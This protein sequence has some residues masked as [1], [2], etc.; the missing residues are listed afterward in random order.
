MIEVRLGAFVRGRLWESMELP[1]A[2]GGPVA[3]R[4]I[5]ADGGVAAQGASLAVE[6][7]ISRGPVVSYGLLGGTYE[8]LPG[9]LLKMSVL[10]GE[11]GVF[12]GALAGPPESVVFGLPSEYVDGIVNGFLAGV[13][14]LSAAPGGL[15]TFDRAA[16]GRIGSSP[17]LFRELAVCVTRLALGDPAPW[18]EVLREALNLRMEAD[19]SR[20]GRLPGQS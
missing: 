14:K 3:N 19:E 17:L 6:V 2:W 4:V 15:L 1:A 5:Q 10:G 18:D 11:Q 8:Q 7:A 9:E 12:D 16:F 13:D 20:I